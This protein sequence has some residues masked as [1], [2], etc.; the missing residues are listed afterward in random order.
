MNYS[1]SNL[2]LPGRKRGKDDTTVLGIESDKRGTHLRLRKASAS[3][4]RIFQA[5]L[6]GT[7]LII[8]AATHGQM[9]IQ[10]ATGLFTPSFRSTGIADANATTWF[11]WQGNL[12]ADPFDNNGFDGATNN[13]LIDNPAVLL[14]AGGRDGSLVQVGTADILAGSN[15]VFAGDPLSNSLEAHLTLQIPTNGT[16]GGGF[17][18]IILQGTG[19]ITGSGA[20]AFPIPGVIAGVSATFISGVNAA[21]LL[22][23]WARYEVPGNADSYTVDIHLPAGANVNPVSIR[24]LVADTQ[25]SNTG[26]AQDTVV[27]PEPST[28][29]LCLGLSLVGC[30][31]RRRA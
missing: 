14:G 17:T 26:Y 19:S 13:E 11:G 29:A 20:T 4:P 5:L 3:K 23:W 27:V 30:L 10:D 22:Q 2:R 31:R 18:T 7:L 1:N 12:D 8:C 9:V 15:N 16:V 24:Q 6:A 28:A 21:G 25:W